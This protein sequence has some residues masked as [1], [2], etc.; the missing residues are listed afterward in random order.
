MKKLVSLV[1]CVFGFAWANIPDDTNIIYQSIIPN[2]KAFGPQQANRIQVVRLTPSQQHFEELLNEVVYDEEFEEM[3]IIGGRDHSPNP[4]V[5]VVGKSK[6]PKP[7]SSKY[8]KISPTI[9]SSKGVFQGSSQI[10]TMCSHLPDR[11]MVVLENNVLA[12]IDIDGVVSTVGSVWGLGGQ[13]VKIQKVNALI[14]LALTDAGEVLSFEYEVVNW[15][16][17]PI[18]S[19][20][21]VNRIDVNLP[22]IFPHETY[23]ILGVR[24]GKYGFVMEVDVKTSTDPSMTLGLHYLAFQYLTTPSPIDLLVASK[25]IGALVGYEDG[26]VFVFVSPLGELVKKSNVKLFL[27]TP[28]KAFD[29]VTVSGS[30]GFAIAANASFHVDYRDSDSQWLIASRGQTV[31]SSFSR[32]DLKEELIRKY[33]G[34]RALIGKKLLPTTF[35]NRYPVECPVGAK[36]YIWASIL[37]ALPELKGRVVRQ[38]EKEISLSKKPHS[39]EITLLEAQRKYNQRIDELGFE[40]KGG[41]MGVCAMKGRGDEDVYLDDLSQAYNDFEISEVELKEAKQ[42]Y[43]RHCSSLAKP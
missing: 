10:Y 39:A 16:S 26:G 33:A 1:F 43:K 7:G 34:A 24:A 17:G 20:G 13:I 2:G 29:S 18:P 35:K 40:D 31:S 6:N 30:S 9:V 23:E 32:V 5:A 25:G 41:M 38:K 8:Y 27:P 14:F 11:V 15:G 21:K 28:Y 36:R 12:E 3:A 22:G 19:I 4:V 42:R 37:N